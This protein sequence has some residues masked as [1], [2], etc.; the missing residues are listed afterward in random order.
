MNIYET[1]GLPGPSR[2][3]LDW[4]RLFRLPLATLCYQCL[5]YTAH[6]LWREKRQRYCVTQR[7]IFFFKCQKTCDTLNSYA[8][9]VGCNIVVY[10]IVFAEKQLRTRSVECKKKKKKFSLDELQS[11][12]KPAGLQNSFNFCHKK[13]HF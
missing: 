4:A 8:L 12:C 3:R 6:R 9:C 10:S 13:R 1:K 5:G 11:C 7:Q 2:G